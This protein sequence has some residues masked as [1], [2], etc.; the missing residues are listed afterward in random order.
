M[1][2]WVWLAALLFIVF[3]ITSFVCAAAL[4]AIATEI[5]SLNELIRQWKGWQ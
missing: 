2:A 3:T 4:S 1:A 5:K